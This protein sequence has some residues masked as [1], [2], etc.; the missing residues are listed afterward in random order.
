M[1]GGK[2]MS[3]EGD[4]IVVH[5]VPGEGARVTGVLKGLIPLLL[6]I[7]LFGLFAGLILP[8]KVGGAVFIGFG[9]IFVVMVW[10]T[11][12]SCNGLESYFKGARGEEIVAVW[13]SA[14]PEGYHVFHDVDVSGVD[15]LDHIVVG[16][17]GVFVIETK[18]WSGSV[19]SDG[20]SLLVNGRQP[21]RSPCTQVAGE[22][23]AL[24][25]F[26][27]GKMDDL[28]PVIPVVCFAGNTFVPDG[29]SSVVMQGDVTVCNVKE[30]CGLI[31]SGGEI[32][33][34]SEIERFIK[35][36]EY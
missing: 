3:F 2:E 25:A 26:L 7:F 29:D 31:K 23:Q 18:F 12:N 27:V 14:L 24:K 22:V 28:P 19:I 11:Y 30:L 5:G 36:L 35:L 21:S 33:S 8:V 13:L 17:T 6:S 9:A 20:S 10:L 34:A 1:A 32:L 16:P 15:S 4:E